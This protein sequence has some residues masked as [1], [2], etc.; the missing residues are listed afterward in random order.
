MLLWP[1]AG[2]S[3]S[4]KMPVG[5]ELRR[6]NPTSVD[7]VKCDGDPIK[8]MPVRAA[9]SDKVVCRRVQPQLVE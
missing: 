8:V 7:S 1:V 3:A 6:K 4:G 2:G 5:K 9:S